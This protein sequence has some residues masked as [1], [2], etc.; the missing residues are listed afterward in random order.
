MAKAYSQILKDQR[1][2]KGFSD[3]WI[4]IAAKTAAPYR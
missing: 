2:S 3:L 1:K 4:T